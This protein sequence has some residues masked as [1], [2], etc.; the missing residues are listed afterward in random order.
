MYVYCTH[1]ECLKGQH[2][3]LW[4]IGSSMGFISLYV[5]MIRSKFYNEHLYLYMIRNKKVFSL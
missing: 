4:K 2:A 5:F 3:V 1:K